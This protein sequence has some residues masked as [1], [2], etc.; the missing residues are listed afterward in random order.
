MTGSFL[1]GPVRRLAL[2]LPVR[3]RRSAGNVGLVGTIRLV[4]G[5]G[6][7]GTY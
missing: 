6:V 3:W 2:D 1:G 4:R 5:L 7:H